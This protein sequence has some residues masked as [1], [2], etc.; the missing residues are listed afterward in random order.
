VTAG[1]QATFVVEYPCD[2]FCRIEVDLVGERGQITL[3]QLWEKA[4]ELHR[5]VHEP[6][7]PDGEAEAAPDAPVVEQ[8]AMRRPAATVFRSAPERGADRRR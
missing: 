8:E 6:E 7:A 5:R 1:P 4:D 2:R 3:Q